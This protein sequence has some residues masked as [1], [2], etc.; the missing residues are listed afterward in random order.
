MCRG[1][2]RY[3]RIYYLL[4][5]IIVV[6]LIP[7]RD[8]HSW[9]PHLR[10]L[11]QGQSLISPFC[12]D[13]QSFI[14]TQKE[15]S[16]SRKCRLTHQL[17]NQWAMVD[18]CWASALVAENIYFSWKWRD[19]NWSMQIVNT[20]GPLNDWLIQQFTEWR[21]QFISVSVCQS[22]PI[23]FCGYQ[24]ISFRFLIMVLK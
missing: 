16:K 15:K 10:Q 7:D 21:H 12:L 13:V 2:F 3:T 17:T 18:P 9:S 24:N 6:S 23:R 1:T 19:F 8:C 4:P 22:Q 14:K 11:H 5:Q 20:D